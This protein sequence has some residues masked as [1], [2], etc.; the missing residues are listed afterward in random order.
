MEVLCVA[1]EFPLIPK[2][3][4]QNSN[5]SIRISYAEY[6]LSVDQDVSEATHAGTCSKSNLSKRQIV[7]RLH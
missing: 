3:R 2:Y 6:G 5:V 7:A 1:I 4:I